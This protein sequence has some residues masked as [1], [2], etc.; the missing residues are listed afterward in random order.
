MG[1]EMQKGGVMLD[2]LERWYCSQTRGNIVKT[3]FGV[4]RQVFE[5]F[6]KHKTLDLKW[7]VVWC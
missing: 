1:M 5:S 7:K 4:V 2:K 6:F 3:P